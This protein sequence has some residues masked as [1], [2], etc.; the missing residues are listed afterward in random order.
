MMERA[1]A[2]VAVASVA[3]GCGPVAVPPSSRAEVAAPAGCPSGGRAPANLDLADFVR[4]DGRT[5]SATPFGRRV[6]GEVRAED[7]Q[8]QVGA[9]RCTLS[10]T[11]GGFDYLPR[12]GDAAFL[13]PGT[14]LWEVRG[15]SPR[16]RIAVRGEDGV[17]VYELEHDPAARHG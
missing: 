4:H 9:V 12:D 11:Y 8:R 15:H 10:E 16:F 14:P 6:Q 3:A 1:R 17:R 7:L 13:A 5:Y 2:L